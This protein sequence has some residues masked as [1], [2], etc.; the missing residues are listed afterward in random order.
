M[1]RDLVP[2]CSSL[3]VI[4][5]NQ[6]G[7]WGVTVYI[8]MSQCDK[9]WC[10]KTAVFRQNINFQIVLAESTSS[11]YQTWDAKPPTL[12]VTDLQTLTTDKS[13]CG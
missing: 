3:C 4:H 7:P 9:A 2:D 11:K 8:L 1:E 10:L 13:V 5:A 12:P 6:K